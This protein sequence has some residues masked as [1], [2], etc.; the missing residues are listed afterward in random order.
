M[1]TGCGFR[2]QGR[3][4]C[5]VHGCLW[6]TGSAA[7]ER[8]VSDAWFPFSSPTCENANDR[9]TPLPFRC[10]FERLPH[11]R[12]V[13]CAVEDPGQAECRPIGKCGARHRRL[14][15]HT[16]QGGYR[17]FPIAAGVSVLFPPKRKGREAVGCFYFRQTGTLRPVGVVSAGLLRGKGSP[18]S[19]VPGG[20]QCFPAGNP[21]ARRKKLHECCWSKTANLEIPGNWLSGVYLGRLTTVRG[22]PPESCWQSYVVLIVWEGGPAD[23]FAAILFKRAPRRY[24]VRWIRASLFHAVTPHEYFSEGVLGDLGPAQFGQPPVARVS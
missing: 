5:C 8:P 2:V 24:R 11:P 10:A 14:A 17:G 6:I 23:S 9:P 20:V 13:S 12:L 3:R 4:L 1:H 18:E 19:V 22:T 7:Q 21:Q 15:T 16:G